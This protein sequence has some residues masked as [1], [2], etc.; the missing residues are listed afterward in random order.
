MTNEER[1]RQAG[2]SPDGK[3]LDISELR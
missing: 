2:R 3:P 1:W